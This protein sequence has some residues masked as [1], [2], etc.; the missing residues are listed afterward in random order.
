M[1]NYEFKSNK[2]KSL[3]IAP[4]ATSKLFKRR[5]VGDRGQVVGGP[6]DSEEN[7]HR[8]ASTTLNLGQGPL[9]LSLE[10]Y[11]HQFLIVWFLEEFVEERRGI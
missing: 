7:V 11:T 9:F 5:E 6:V 1:Y 8:H 4:F 3:Q 2:I 10:K